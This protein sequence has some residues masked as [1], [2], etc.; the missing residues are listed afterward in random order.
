M[1][2]E[3]DAASNRNDTKELFNIVEK[4]NGRELQNIAFLS[5]QAKW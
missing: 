3:D 2:V 4:L 5:K 1:R